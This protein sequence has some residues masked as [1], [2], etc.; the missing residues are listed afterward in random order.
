MTA[1]F[2]KND[3][4]LCKRWRLSLKKMIGIIE[5]EDKYL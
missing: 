4:C 5:K 1:V 2:V 3:D